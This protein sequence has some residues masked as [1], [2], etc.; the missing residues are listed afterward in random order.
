M[1]SKFGYRISYS[2]HGILVEHFILSNNTQKIAI[3]STTA[4][5]NSPAI[6]HIENFDIRDITSIINSDT[7]FAS[8]IINGEFTVSEWDK[9]LP[10]F[11][12]HL[13]VAHFFLKQQPVGT[14]TFTADKKDDQSINATVNLTDNGNDLKVKGNYYSITAHNSLMPPLTLLD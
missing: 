13:E 5:L 4:A 6:V 7:L 8:G 11:T 1:G 12:G 9:K 14:I 3:E 2:P 10:A